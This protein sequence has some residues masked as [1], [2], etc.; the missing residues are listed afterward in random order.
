MSS[1][2]PRAPLAEAD[3]NTVGS[4]N[5]NVFNR[6]W[7]RAFSG[8]HADLKQ[9]HQLHQ[10]QLA[11]AEE[12]T[13]KLW[14]ARFPNSILI[15]APPKTSLS[16]ILSQICVGPILSISVLESDPSPLVLLELNGENQAASLRAALRTKR[17]I[18]H[19][20]YLEEQT[21]SV[22]W[23]KKLLESAPSIVSEMHVSGFCRTLEIFKK[24]PI[25]REQNY[26]KYSGGQ[27]Y[28]TTKP[29]LTPTDINP[30]FIK[31]AFDAIAPVIQVRP[32]VNREYIT[33]AVDFGNLHDAA[34]AKQLFEEEKNR[35]EYSPMPVQLRFDGLH[36]WEIDFT[37][38]ITA[39]RVTRAI[40]QSDSFD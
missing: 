12:T 28:T 34:L 2:I 36:E 26:I 10:Q 29:R 21:I 11:A 25:C 1:S 33:Y 39:R 40:N 30:V 16:S 17:L 6:S 7:W 37:Q 22:E 15:S 18:V 4:S 5:F 31:K 32:M 38:D 27:F 13:R 8:K 14:K 23:A 3:C 19:G 20:R 35:P 24:A 9:E